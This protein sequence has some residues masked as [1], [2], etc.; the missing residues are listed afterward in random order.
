ML[1]IIEKASKCELYG[2]ERGLAKYLPLSNTGGREFISICH[3]LNVGRAAQPI[4]DLSVTFLHK[5]T[6]TVDK[7][8][9]N[10]GGRNV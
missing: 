3:V 4:S 1:L 9:G 5:F 7:V 8:Y 2:S 10:R 6:I